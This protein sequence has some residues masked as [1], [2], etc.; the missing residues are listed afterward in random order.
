MPVLEGLAELPAWNL[1]GKAA[2]VNELG[3]E[4]CINDLVRPLSEALDHTRLVKV[5]NTLSKSALVDPLAVDAFN[6]Y[7]NLI[8]RDVARAK[9]I[10]PKILLLS[11]AGSWSEPHELCHGAEG[12][13]ANVIL[14]ERQAHILTG[15]IV[16]CGRQFSN[17]A[18][19]MGG[20]IAAIDTQIQE[21]EGTLRNY[22]R[23]WQG[24]VGNAPIGAVVALLGQ[25]VRDL[26][27]EYLK[28]HSFDWLQSQ[29]GWK[30]PRGD[31]SDSRVWMEGLPAAQALNQLKVGVVE[32]REGTV[33]VT[34]LFGHPMKASRADNPKTLIAG[35][36]KHVSSQRYSLPLARIDHTKL[37][38]N[39]LSQLLRRTAEYLLRQLYNQPEINL[40]ALWK[41]LEKSDQLEI[42][43]ARALLLEN[44][45]F[46]LRQL[47]AHNRSE[48]LKKAL[49]DNDRA[50]KRLT[51]NSSGAQSNES[52]SEGLRDQ[53]RVAREAVASSLVEDPVAQ[54]AVLDAVRHKLRDFQ[55]DLQSVPFELFQNADDA[56][57]ELG[58]CEAYPDKLPRVPEV[59]RTFLIEAD[60]DRL[61]FMHWGRSINDRGPAA[62][63]GEKHGWHRDLEKMLV[64]SSSDKITPDLTGKFGLG[65]KSVLLA[66]DR[67]KIISGKMHVE[68]VAGVLP[69]PWRDP[70][71][72]L[73]RLTRHSTN[74]VRYRGTLI[75]LDARLNEEITKRVELLGGILS[76]FGHAI[77]H[78]R[79]RFPG[80]SVNH[81]WQPEPIGEGIEL[82]KWHL[83]DG[84]LNDGLAFRGVVGAV[85]LGLGPTGFRTL[86]ASIPSVWVTAPT[87][88]EESL[89]IAFSAQFALDAGRGRLAG[90]M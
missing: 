53:V 13:D 72:A 68:I 90:D 38:D 34:N 15:I 73:E 9:S 14:D 56:A 84:D 79:M 7:L 18:D 66:C 58:L 4:V 32:I 23:P 21:A 20:S 85:F 40:D 19:H 48:S 67:P 89:G 16:D 75:E 11:M 88:E 28:P 62:M 8:P 81:H 55:Y 45:P 2:R 44:L 36:P 33:T 80:R 49:D 82:G 70:Q 6:I 29:L 5:L 22:F 86:P 50:R 17:F 30:I 12:L 87:R 26:A 37:A 52:V 76:V 39:D 27:I 24:W 78:V 60:N 3:M 41:T 65:F 69:E 42:E 10:L 61:W 54:E 25:D 47:G 46:Y 43:V 1:V 63:E 83:G 59:A 74:S 35:E 31:D 51:E 71:R 64:L 57:I 77:R